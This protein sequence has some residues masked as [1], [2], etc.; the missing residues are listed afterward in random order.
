MRLIGSYRATLQGGEFDGK[1]GTYA[2]ARKRGRHFQM[3][4]MGMALAEH[5]EEGLLRHWSGLACFAA[6][7]RRP[8]FSV[9]SE[10]FRLVEEPGLLKRVRPEP[11]DEVLVF[12]GLVPLA[13]GDLLCSDF[14]TNADRILWDTVDSSIFAASDSVNFYTEGTLSP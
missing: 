6:T 4:S 5:W 3:L 9:L 1:R 11:L 2:H 12:A 10:V 14:P 8:L 7:Y 13:A